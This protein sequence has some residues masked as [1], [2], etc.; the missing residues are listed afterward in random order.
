MRDENDFVDRKKDGDGREG[1]GDKKKK[2]GQRIENRWEMKYIRTP[3]ARSRGYDL[4]RHTVVTASL[5]RR[6][7]DGERERRETKRERMRERR[8]H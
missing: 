1:V 2:N 6:E 4:S 5:S 8:S 3:G 7:R